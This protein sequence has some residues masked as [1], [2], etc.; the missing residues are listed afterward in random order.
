MDL[1]FSL[2]VLL[3]TLFF[4]NND[5][6][7][8]A[9]VSCPDIIKLL[10]GHQLTPEALTNNQTTMHFAGPILPTIVNKGIVPPLASALMQMVYVCN[11]KVNLFGMDERKLIQIR[12][13]YLQKQLNALDN[14][15][16][17]QEFKPFVRDEYPTI[18]S[19]VT[20]EMMKS[21]E[22]M[23]KQK[24]ESLEIRKE[25][26]RMTS[27]LK[28]QLAR[29]HI[30]SNVNETDREIAK[31]VEYKA[32]RTLLAL[33]HD[34]HGDNFTFP[35][36]L[37]FYGNWETPINACDAIHT[38][39]TS[40]GLSDTIAYYNDLN[41]ARSRITDS[42]KNGKPVVITVKL[43]GQEVRHLC[44]CGLFMKSGSP[45]DII[46]IALKDEDIQGIVSRPLVV[47]ADKLQCTYLVQWSQL[48]PFLKGY[49][50]FTSY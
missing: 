2:F 19:H 9:D 43:E 39:L 25:Y 15:M 27:L 44:L 7:I 26:L 3:A 11:K 8:S 5:K 21:E 37:S 12:I 31:N 23:E 47:V 17:T 18:L 20:T 1:F 36:I 16:P 48:L 14:K 22:I 28:L 24:S 49:Y 40:R 41:N 50:I 6:A 42:L 4:S 29:Q 30:L 34:T 35:Y 46:V 32:A 45:L 13:N 38:F 33:L 10:H